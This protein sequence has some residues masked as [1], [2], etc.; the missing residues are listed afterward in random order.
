M[1]ERGTGIVLR[2]RPFTETSVVVQ[3]VTLEFGRLATVAKGA[4]RAKSAF[5]GKLDLFYTAD[6]SFQRS[7][8][9]DLHTLREVQ[10]RETHARLR[11]DLGWVHQASYFTLLLEKS[12][13]AEAPVPEVYELLNRALIAV[14][15][16]KPSARLVFA[17]EIK[18]LTLLGYDPDLAQLSAEPRQLAAQL[19]E[20]S[21]TENLEKPTPRA[22]KELNLF[23]QTSIAGAIDHLPA[24]REK[25]LA[26]AARALKTTAPS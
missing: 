23:L 12:T 20:T 17:F 24:Q 9:S 26:A 14:P 4:R 8:R 22:Y 15:K 18:L 10:L 13:E 6:L 7:R 25:A 21:F 5:V 19:T 3:W 2:T 11:E 1:E 16:S